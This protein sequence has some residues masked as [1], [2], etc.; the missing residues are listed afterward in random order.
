MSDEPRQTPALRGETSPAA[1]RRPLSR[2][3][4][5]G[6]RAERLRW[7]VV[8]RPRRPFRIW[9]PV[10]PLLILFSPLILFALGVAVFLPGRFGL[11][12]ASFVLG[13]GRFIEAFNGDQAS[14]AED[15][16][17]QLRLF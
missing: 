12:P 10:T 7:R 1:P 6:Q 3:A 8:A 5:M 4:A 13:V 2:W 14:R 15:R 11:N 9:V 17:V 16:P